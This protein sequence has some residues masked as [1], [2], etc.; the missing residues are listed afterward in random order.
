MGCLNCLIALP[1]P[2]I[3][4][5]SAKDVEEIASGVETLYRSGKFPLDRIYAKFCN[6]NR[7]KCS[8]TSLPSGDRSTASPF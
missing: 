4:S 1:S 3:S 8:P 5:Y 6:Y 7:F 2:V